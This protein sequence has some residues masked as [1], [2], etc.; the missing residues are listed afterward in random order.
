TAEIADILSGSLEKLGVEN[1]V[2]ECTQIDPEEFQEYDIC[3][4]A[5]YTYGSA[6]NLPEEI[7][8]LYFDL[9][10]L[11]LNGKIYGVLGS[12]DSFYGY[13]CK[14]VDDFDE[15]FKLTGAIRGSDVVKVELRA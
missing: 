2:V 5:T 4:V 8:Y 11:D 7:E 15:Q 3:V 14:A 6:G 13:F 9:E 1:L 10:E 12:G